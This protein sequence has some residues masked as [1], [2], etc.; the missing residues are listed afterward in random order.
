MRDKYKIY[1]VKGYK[2]T[3]TH[4][5]TDLLEAR[6]DNFIPHIVTQTKPQTFD[7][8]IHI[9][10]HT[11]YNLL[12][13]CNIN[14]E[15]HLDALSRDCD[16]LRK[17]VEVLPIQLKEMLFYDWEPVRKIFNSPFMDV[18]DR[19]I[20]SANRIRRLFDVNTYARKDSIAVPYEKYILLLVDTNGGNVDTE[21]LYN[22]YCAVVPEDARIA[23]VGQDILMSCLGS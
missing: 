14:V 3:K 18:I 11:A 6:E 12:N 1:T 19:S 4:T 2:M 15:E 20:M 17:K 7:L 10:T 5:I 22:A 9:M 21:A 8:P 16:A 23:G 13:D